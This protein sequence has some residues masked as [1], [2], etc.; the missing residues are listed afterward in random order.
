MLSWFEKVVWSDEKWWTLTL[1]PNRKNDVI[2]APKG[3]DPHEEVPCR[4]QGEQ[5]A[6]CWV[7]IIDGTILDIKWF[8]VVVLVSNPSIFSH[9]ENPSR[10]P[11]RPGLSTKMVT[12]LMSMHSSMVN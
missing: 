10:H 12:P 5:K 6:M 11:P 8:V 1:A 4:N 2:W 9:L 3:W 7:G